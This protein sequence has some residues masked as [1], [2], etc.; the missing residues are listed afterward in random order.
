MSNRIA[1]DEWL[2]V[3]DGEYLADFIGAGGAAVKFAVAEEGGRRALSQ[4][5]KA[6][7]ESLGYLFVHLDAA[8]CRAHM[9]QDLFFG[10]ARQVDW[11]LLARR[12]IQG[13]F[14][15]EGFEVEGIDAKEP[16]MIDSIIAANNSGRDYIGRVLRPHLESRIFRN[17]DLSKAFRIAMLH[18]CRFEIQDTAG[19]EQYPGQPLLDWLTGEDNRIGQLRDFQ[20]RTRIDRTTARYFLESACHWIRQAGCPGMLLVLDNARVTV[21]R[22]PRD[23]LRYYTKAMTLDHYEVLREFIDDADR[24]SGLLFV[25]ATDYGFL[26]ESSRSS[27]GWIIYSA[28]RTRIMDDVRDRNVVNPVSS[29][30]RI[31]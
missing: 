3:I 4:A 10:M 29:L 17:A 14:V 15:E 19:M 24:L 26:D 31:S 7:G 30:V 27:R 6:R 18:L 2:E 22:N 1:L 12:V 20:I 9:P 13:F 11:R 5:L 23:S 25:V 21:G 8:T 16:R 28:L